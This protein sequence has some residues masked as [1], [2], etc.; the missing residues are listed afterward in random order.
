MVFFLVIFLRLFIPLSILRSPLLG[1]FLSIGLDLLDWHL[2]QAFAPDQISQYQE[3]DKI[4]DFYYI[5][6]E[7]SVVLLWKDVRVKRTAVFLFLYR[8]I[9]VLLFEVFQMRFLLLVFPNIF[10]VFFIF[11]L[12]YSRFKKTTALS[13]KE[14]I[15]F[16]IFLGVPK[17]IQEYVMHYAQM[18]Y[19]RWINWW[20]FL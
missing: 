20:E 6:L 9:G 19:W 12:I 14:M 17:I 7:A 15:L 2:F 18:E 4:L 3:L 1:A 16:F 13:L 8:T 10:E 11:Y 5:G